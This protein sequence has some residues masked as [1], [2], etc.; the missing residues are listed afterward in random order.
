MHPVEHPSPRWPRAVALCAALL[1]GAA[2]CGDDPFAF[3]WS[4]TPDTVLLYSMA[5]PEMNLQS[6]FNFR[7]RRAIE[8]EAPSS[9]GS[10][11]AAVDTRGGE[12]VLLP[13][14]ALGVIGAARITTLAGL[15]LDDVRQA[16]GDTLVYVGDRPVTV[17]MGNVY[18]I[19]TNRSRGSYGTSCTYYAKMAPVVIDAAGGTLTFEYVTKPVCNSTDL[20]PHQ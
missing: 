18:V 3:D 20:V 7:Q 15:K 16:P 14:G 4:D 10:W 6:A 1:V 2:G 17:A 11:D 13:P 12:V 8:V 9:A 19:R 5:R